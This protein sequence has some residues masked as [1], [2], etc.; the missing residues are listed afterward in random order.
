MVD[1]DKLFKDQLIDDYTHFLN[2]KKCVEAIDTSKDQDKRNDY[3]V[4]TIVAFKTIKARAIQY[5]FIKTTMGIELTDEES[6]MIEE[7]VN[8]DTIYIEVSIAIRDADNKIQH[9]SIL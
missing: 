7:I 1:F 6:K 3:I 9:F 2:I 5:G 8:Y 4:Y